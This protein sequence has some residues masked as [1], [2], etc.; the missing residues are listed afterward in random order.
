MK[1]LIVIIAI[2][3][4]LA[5]MSAQ[6][7]KGVSILGDSY[8]TFQGFVTPDSN[9][10]WYFTTPNPELTDV[11]AVTQTWWHRLI[12]DQG[13]RLCLNNSFSGST[14]CNTGYN[15]EDYSGRSFIA[16]MKNLG[17]PD[18]IFIFGGTND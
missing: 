4:S 18:I 8:S 1:R 14:I 2:V 15:G 5:S 7:R 10:L 3:A 11:N 17:S 13:W 16:R 6:S 12:K 9:F